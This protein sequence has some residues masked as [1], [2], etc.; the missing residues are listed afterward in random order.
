[1]N[2]PMMHPIHAVILGIVEGVTEFLPVSSTGHLILAV[3]AL[4]LDE[5]PSLKSAADSFSIIIQCGAILAVV[6]LYWSRM[7]QLLRGVLGRDAAGRRLLLNLIAAFLPVLLVWP[8][9]IK[10]ARSYL[11]TPGPVL[12]A[13]LLGGIWMIWLGRGGPRGTGTT[14]GTGEASDA[15]PPVG[16]ELDDLTLR[17]ALLVGLFQ[18]VSIWPGSSRA[19]M[20]IAGGMVVGLRPRAAAEFSFL[21]GLPTIAAACLYEAYGLWKSSQ[22]A[23]STAYQD[24]CHAIPLGVAAVGLVTSFVV[25]MVVVRWFVRFIERFGLALF[26]WYRVLLA[27]VMAGLLAAG[28]ITL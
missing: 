20:T 17:Q 3:A 1:M 24:F 19:L 9:L 18:C 15:A 12:V 5:P 11:F 28:A 13:I 8:V 10:P 14:P 7:A 16:I 26:G 6:S 23:D 2:H 4:G 21:L 27:V 22:A 25:A